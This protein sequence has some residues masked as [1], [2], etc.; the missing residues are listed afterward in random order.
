MV[1]LAE[2]GSCSI[3]GG[4]AW[5]VQKTVSRRGLTIAHGAFEARETVL[6]CASKCRHSCGAHVI[7][8]A[9]AGQLV[10]SR[11]VGYDVVAF[12]GTERYL[13]HR[14]REQIR[15]TL[16]SKHGIAI[17]SGEVSALQRLFVDYLGRLEASHGEG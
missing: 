17:S 7:R 11:S 16:E 9:L 5:R 1:G 6:E 3:C 13:H 4:D 12:V 8:K 14:R 2:P 10:P 15:T